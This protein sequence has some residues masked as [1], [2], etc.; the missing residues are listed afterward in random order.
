[1]KVARLTPVCGGRPRKYGTAISLIVLC[2]MFTAQSNAIDKKSVVAMWLLDD[3]KGETAP[4]FSGNGHDGEIHN[5]KLVNGQQEFGKALEFDGDD[6]V[7][8]GMEGYD[9]GDVITVVLWLKHIG[10]EGDYRGVVNNGYWDKGGWEIRFGR[11]DAG[12][13]LG[14]RITT[15]N[16]LTLELHP[17]AN[18]WHHIALVYDGKTV[19]YYLDGS[20]EADGKLTGNINEV[21][22]PVVM[23]HNGQDG[24]WY[25]GLLDEVAIF[26]VAL[27]EDDIKSIMEK[28]LESAFAVSPAGKLATTWGLI[29][30]Q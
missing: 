15:N 30:S 11:E 12:T 23:G 22:N 2:L 1:M 4:D 17:S 28:G 13:R 25:S 5:A 7:D 26:S 29:K 8:C 18:E 20:S 19:N 10:K 14:S 16:F 24:E 9:F 27:T 6:F 21:A 3:V